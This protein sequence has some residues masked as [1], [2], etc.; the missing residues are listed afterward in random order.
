MTDGTRAL[1]T[2]LDALLDRALDL[3]PAERAAWLEQVRHE[4]PDI[5][6]ELEALLAQEAE[7]DARRFLESDGWTGEFT[8]PGSLAGRQLGAYTLERPIGHGGMG[9]VWLARRS[10][11]R[12]VGTAAVKFLNLALLDSVGGER[13]RREGTALARLAHPNIARLI[14]AGVTSGG[15][16]Y[17]VLEHVAGLRIDRYCDDRRLPPKARLRLFLDVLAAVGHAHANLIVHR[18]LKPS[19]ILVTEEGIPKLLDFGIAKLLETDAALAE[20]SALTEVGGVALTPEYAAP[21]QA[22]GGPVTTATDVYALGVLLYVLLAGRHPTGEGARTPAEHI[23]GIVD[24]EPPRLSAAVATNRQPTNREATDIDSAAAPPMCGRP[25]ERL[26]RL[27]RG[28]LDNIVA[29]ALK[30]DPS[31]RYATV[32]ALADDIRRYLSHQ[33]V[34]ARPDSVRYRAAKFVRRNRTAVVLAALAGVAVIGGLAG[35]ITQAQR[36][37]RHALVAEEQRARANRETR[38]ASEERDFALRQLSRAEAINDLNT[39]VL[40]DAAPSGKPFTVGALLERAERMVTREHSESDVNRVEM[41]VALGQQHLSQDEDAKAL[42]ILTNAY[43]LSR[44]VTDH[45][46]R[47]KAACALSAALSRS[48]ELDRAEQLAHEGLA[49]L[50]SE[51]LYAVSRIECLMRTAETARNSGNAALSVERMEAAQALLRELRFPSAMLEA[52]VLMDLAEAYREAERFRS[53]VA[54]F[55]PAYARLTALGRE[56][57]QTAG[58]LLN[59]WGL[60]LGQLGQPNAAAPLLRKAIAVSS[61]DGGERAVSPMLLNNYA[62]SLSELFRFREAQRYAELAYAR[63]RLAGDET[64]VNQALLVR[65]A[66]YRHLG[67]LDRAAGTLAEVEP[68][69]RRMLPAGHVALSTV[70]ANAALLATARGDWPTALRRI[71]RAV[72]VVTASGRNAAYLASFVRE[73]AD[74]KRELGQLDEA[75]GD[76]EQ[77]LAYAQRISEPNA[78]S[79][80][81]G[82]AYLTL[83][84]VL[85]ARGQREAAH[86]AFASALANLQPALGQG[87]PTTR[88]AERLAT[89]TEP[90]AH[91]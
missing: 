74:I 21:E 14:D 50:P 70:D 38:L 5:V 81:L 33:P 28:D 11:G 12:F 40:T 26:A 46:A 15:Q 87:H 8:L 86:G 13:F 80:N 31:E 78:P 39:F 30:K 66:V 24:R 36:A 54:K 82:L 55:E 35:T 85:Q 73:R 48:R 9:T 20:R 1:L 2:T 47:A 16:P 27:Y 6:P 64:V 37:T 23:R 62:R 76:A 65:T 51:P 58:T 88:Q 68:R 89:Q 45:L 3:A 17:L 77:A 52:R 22:L 49:E 60:A 18:D 42:T 79:S 61:A 72:A 63:A 19:N 43:E 29:K 90:G 84:R 83:G 53:A 32:A 44:G 7:L 25:P 67:Q 34:S 41:L 59:N 75:Q 71:N 69:L 91:Q 4:R 57:T 10:D 56:N